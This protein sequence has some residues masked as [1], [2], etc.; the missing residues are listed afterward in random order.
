VELAWILVVAAIAAGTVVAARRCL[1]VVRVVGVSM[2]PALRPGERVLSV[3]RPYGR[4]VRRGDLVVHR[5]PALAAAVAG[6]PPGV[7]PSALPLLVKRVVALAGEAIPGG[8]VVPPGCVFV[9]GDHP[10]STDSRHYGPIPL[11]GVV[12][13]VVALLGHRAPAPP[14]RRPDGETA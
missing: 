13:R 12:G 6:L 9:V 1:L 11:T 3:R 7:P 8:G 2:L 14:R 10:E 5:L 4:P